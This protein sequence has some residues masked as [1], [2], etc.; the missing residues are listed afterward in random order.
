MLNMINTKY[1]SME[2]KLTTIL[3]LLRDAALPYNDTAIND[4]LRF[5]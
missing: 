1:V 2:E 3:N 4:L 5:A